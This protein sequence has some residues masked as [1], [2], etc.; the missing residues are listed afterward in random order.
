MM[1]YVV[2]ALFLVVFLG[3]SRPAE[4]TLEFRIAD[5]EP[6]PGL[7][8][9][10]FAPTGERF[11]LHDEVLMDE[12]DVEAALATTRHGGWAVELALTSVGTLKF[13]QLTEENVGKHCAMVL[14]GELASAPRIMATISSGRAV[15]MGDFD[16]AEA[17]RIARG[18]SRR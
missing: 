9:M 10:T 1:R 6:A 17:R 4:M 12:T 18:L 11:Y 14:N 5:T 13:E 7:T 16:E 15:L 2:P 3:C 8:E